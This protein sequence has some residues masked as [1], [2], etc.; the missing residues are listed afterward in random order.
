MK[1]ILIVLSALVVACVAHEFQAIQDLA[2]AGWKVKYNKTYTGVEEEYRRK[3]WE[4]NL[5]YIEEFNA[6]E[7]SYKLGPNHFADLV[8]NLYYIYIFYSIITQIV[9]I[10]LY[11]CPELIEQTTLHTEL[12]FGIQ[13]GGG[14][15]IL[16]LAQ[17]SSSLERRF[18]PTMEL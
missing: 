4:N 1:F 3:I 7:H 15:G 9:C 11:V 16:A 5:L 17:R 14:G 2:W 10:Y 12:N 8:S 6:E 18:T 13:G